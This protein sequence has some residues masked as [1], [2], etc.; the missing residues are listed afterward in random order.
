MARYEVY[1][2]YS[3]TGAA[4]A[5]VPDLW[6]CHLFADSRKHALAQLGDRIAEYLEWRCSMGAPTRA[7]YGPRRLEVVEEAYGTSPWTVSGVNAFFR[8]DAQPLT[9]AQLNDALKVMGAARET[10]MRLV[11]GINPRIL[12]W[13]PYPGGRSVLRHLSHVESC[14]RWYLSRLGIMT[15]RTGGLFLLPHLAETRAAVTAALRRLDETTRTVI[16]EPH[17]DAANAIE[18]WT[19]RKVVRRM[20]EHELE[21]IERIR[22]TIRRYSELP[23]STSGLALT[24]R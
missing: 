22:D 5:H 2:E 18:K 10:L 1:L 19:A 9:K 23:A 16:F 4:M 8:W 11:D 6:G 13:K 7:G 15:E 12:R 24:R 14:E 21:H 20:V 3:K 17:R